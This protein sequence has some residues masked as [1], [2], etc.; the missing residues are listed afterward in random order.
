VFELE[1]KPHVYV[2][3]DGIAHRRPV[4]LGVASE[5]IIE[6]LG[7]VAGDDVVVADGN[8]GITEGMPLAA[9]EPAAAEK[10]AA[11]PAAAGS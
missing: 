7:G 10:A 6:V 11:E 2:I 4:Q 9:A 1:G 8:A 3:D 5:D